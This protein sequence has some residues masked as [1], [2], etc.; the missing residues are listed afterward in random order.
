M[1]STIVWFRHDLRIDDHPA[2][3][4]AAERGAVVALFILD[5]AA[6]GEWPA[7]GAARWW[8]HHSLVALRA[9]LSALGAKL[10]V[11]RGAAAGILAEVASASGADRVV[12]SA[13]HEPAAISHERLVAA[14]LARRGVECAFMPGALL[15]EPAE[16]RSG[17]GTPFKVFTPFW[18]AC[19]A[20]GFDTVPLRPPERLEDGSRGLKEGSI[21][22]L[23]LLPSIPWAAEFPKRWQPGE[24]GAKARWT[25]FAAAAITS[26]AGDRNLCGAEGTS[27]LSP[28]LHFGE[29]SPRR[30]WHEVAKVEHRL[31]PGDS[32]GSAG[33]GVKAALE[34]LRVFRAEMGWR[35]FAHHVLIHQPKTP[36]QPLRPEFAS[37]PWRRDAVL[38]RAWQKGLTGYPLVDA[39]MRQ[40][41]RTGWMHNRVRMV[42]ASFLVKHLLQPWLDGARWFWDTLV[43][44]DL[45]N[46]TLGWQW[47]AGCGADAAPYFRIFNPVSQGERFDADGAYVREFVPELARLPAEWIHQPWEAQPAVLR[48]AGVEIGRTYPAPIVEHASAR[49][50]ALDALAAV[51]PLKE[52][53]G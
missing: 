46:N 15:H 11:R 24:E 12:A 31:R 25:R 7:G 26:Y 17:S 8:L 21:D 44:A 30:L 52:K 43:D 9:R 16:I 51:S 45:A 53:S 20:R 27:G 5:D 6:E 10:L 29:I 13:R 48:A 40:L 3:R 35:E 36:T 47:T 38:L 34:S 32:R 1:P 14:A 28:H 18:K 4:S 37:F 49:A 19:L 2:L 42:V 39:G 33:D 23:G 50:K 22:E 41:W